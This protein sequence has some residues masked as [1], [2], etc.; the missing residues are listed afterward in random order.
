MVIHTVDSEKCR[1]CG[2]CVEICSLELWELVDAGDN[3]KR[4][5]VI[6]EAKDVCHMCLA[7]HDVCPEQAI[8]ITEA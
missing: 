3:K 8:T 2:K 4:A 7:C 6:A 1:G 5:Q